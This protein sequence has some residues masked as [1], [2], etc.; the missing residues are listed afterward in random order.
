[1][2]GDA[3]IGFTLPLSQR[4]RSAVLASLCSVL[5]AAVRREVD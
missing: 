1:M 5:A 4:R 3:F 2:V